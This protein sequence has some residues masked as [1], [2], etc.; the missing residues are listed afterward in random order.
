MGGTL[1]AIEAGF[2]QRQIQEAAYRAQQAID[3]GEAVVVG[4]NRFVQQDDERRPTS[5]TSRSASIPR[6]SGGRSSACAPCAPAAA[7][8]PGARR[9]P[10]VEAAARGRRQPRAADHRRRRGA[11]HARRDCR[12]AAA[13]VRRVSGRCT[14]DADR[15]STSST[16]PWSFEAPVARHRRRRRQ[17]S[18]RAGRNARPGRRIGQRQVG[19]RV[20]HPAPAAAA[21]PDHRRPRPVRRARPADAAGARDAR[22]CAAPAS[23]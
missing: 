21:G 2:I 13:R 9:S 14:P 5:G 8:R 10:R 4:V 6:S 20:L 22:R 1:A 17:L 16:S 3:A 19:D 7:R 23:R 15:C 11:R 12:R 18:D